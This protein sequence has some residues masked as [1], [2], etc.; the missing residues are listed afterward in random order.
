MRR[1]QVFA[2]INET[3]LSNINN[4]REL[5]KTIGILDIIKIWITNYKGF[6]LK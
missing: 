5:R 2:V 3:D 4:I 6:P 1:T